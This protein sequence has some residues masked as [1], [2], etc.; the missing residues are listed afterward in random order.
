M[1]PIKE[2]LQ[3]QKDDLVWLVESGPEVTVDDPNG[4]MASNE[5]DHARSMK[6]RTDLNNFEPA[7][8]CKD[9]DDLH[10]EFFELALQPP[11]PV[12]RVF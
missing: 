6:P 7:S 8:C 10:H 1:L 3:T 9:P 11:V 4:F 12:K 2:K 5:G